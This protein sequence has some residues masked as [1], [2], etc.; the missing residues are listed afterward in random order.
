MK[1]AWERAKGTLPLIIRAA[2]RGSGVDSHGH[3]PLSVGLGHPELDLGEYHT[4]VQPRP[5]L[6]VS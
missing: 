3:L 4:A 2:G 6:D 1:C 5:S